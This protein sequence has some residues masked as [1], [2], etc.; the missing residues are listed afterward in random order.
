MRFG[1][2]WFAAQGYTG[3]GDT[4]AATP[5]HAW[6]TTIELR[7]T[8]AWQH[9]RHSLKFGG[10]LVF[11]P[12][13]EELAYAISDPSFF[14]PET[15]PT[16]QFSDHKHD[17]EQSLFVQDTIAAG[18]FTINAGP[19]FRNPQRDRRIVI[20]IVPRNR[21]AVRPTVAHADCANLR[22]LPRPRASDRECDVTEHT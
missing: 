3:I 15:A 6:D 11:A 16:F 5:I 17:R 9:G 7:D 12:V 14:D 8:F 21:R 10:D 2:P 18:A 20:A 1:A 4:F 19:G 13:R 22:C